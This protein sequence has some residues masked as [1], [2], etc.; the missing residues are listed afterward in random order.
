MKEKI[1]T[2][3][4]KLTDNQIKKIAVKAT[5]LKTADFDSRGFKI[6]HEITV[7]DVKSVFAAI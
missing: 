4:N 3:L 5:K 7:E 2:I 1:S 6:N